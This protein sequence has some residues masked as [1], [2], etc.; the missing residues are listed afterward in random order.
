MKAPFDLFDQYSIAHAEFDATQISGSGGSLM[1]Q[2]SLPLRLDV[3]HGGLAP[4]QGLEI[5]SI[6]GE[7]KIGAVLSIMSAPVRIGYMMPSSKY[8]LKNYTY[9]LNFQLNSLQIAELERIRSG[10][11]LEINVCA[12]LI[13]NKL[14]AL[15]QTPPSQE[16]LRPVWG[17]MQQ[18]E[19][20]MRLGLPVPRDAWIS[21]V[22]PAIGYGIIHL[23]ELPAIPLE[24][25]A[26]LGHAFKALKQAQE[27]HKIGLYDDS[28]G[29]CRVALDKFFES[30]EKTDEKNVTRRMPVLIKSWETKLGKAT[31]DW[32]N[33]SF[34]AI[35]S[36]ANVSHHS[37]NS[38]FDQFTSQMMI[39]ITTTMV[40]YVAR[41]AASE[42]S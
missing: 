42:K 41:T 31:Y 6:S 25:F 14:H 16:L 10:G 1:P 24:S 39:A 33:N 9:V 7:I 23:I 40:S 29:K 4:K 26:N 28:A 32:L 30:E 2:L 20:N 12:K 17:Y 37:P 36:A 15:G 27:F 21:R 18:Y 8:P 13:I 19:L 5:V 22:L 11:D 34:S 3:D 38:H 35:K